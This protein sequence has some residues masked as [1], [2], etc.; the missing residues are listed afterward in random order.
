MQGRTA[1]S[2]T[3]SNYQMQGVQPS[4]SYSGSQQYSGT[5][6]APSQS[7]SGY[8]PRRTADYNSGFSKETTQTPAL[9]SEPSLLSQLV[10]APSTKE[11]HAPTS[12]PYNPMGSPRVSYSSSGLNDYGVPSQYHPFSSNKVENSS[13]TSHPNF[14]GDTANFKEGAR[15]QEAKEIR[16]SNSME[17]VPISKKESSGENEDK[18]N[19]SAAVISR[20]MSKFAKEA[21]AKEEAAL[22]PSAGS[23]DGLNKFDRTNLTSPWSGFISKKMNHRVQVDAFIIQGPSDLFETTPPIY[24]F[25][26]THRKPFE[27]LAKKEIGAIVILKLY[28]E[29]THKQF[30]E[31]YSSYFQQKKKAGVVCSSLKGYTLY[32][33]PPGSFAEKYQKIGDDELLLILAK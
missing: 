16:P 8:S 2:M 28:Q 27:E 23:F 32:V 29:T 17:P 10:G 9:A 33:V 31:Q 13:P 6:G 4:Q 11:D 21:Q 12:Q 5:Y 3:P 20:L 30:Y 18:S 24:Y 26:I 1:T 14:L 15:L 25:N 7:N 19:Q 22:A